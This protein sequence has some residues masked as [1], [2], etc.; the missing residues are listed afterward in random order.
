MSF[1]ALVKYGWSEHFA[2]HFQPLVAKDY[3][4]GRVSFQNQHIYRVYTEQGELVAETTGKLRYDAESHEDLPAVGDWVALRFRP[5]EDKARIQGV[6][7]RR[8]KFARKTVGT[9]TEAQIVG[10][11]IYVFSVFIGQS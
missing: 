11:F 3:L 7:P 9:K 6:L 5:Q 2:D 10:A 1:E 8:S 4:P